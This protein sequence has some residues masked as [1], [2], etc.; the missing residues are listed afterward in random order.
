MP[1]KKKKIVKMEDIIPIT[2]TL[3]EER[4]V[5]LP[6]EGRKDFNENLDNI[7]I[8]LKESAEEEIPR[9]EEKSME[10]ELNIPEYYKAE[11]TTGPQDLFEEQEEIKMPSRKKFNFKPWRK[12]R[13]ILIFA[14]IIIVLLS[15]I[16][17]PGLSKT[18]VT[19]KPKAENAHFKTELT[20]DKGIA[21]IDMSNNKIPAQL[22]KVEKEEK[23]EFP[24]TAEKDLAERAKGKITV[25]NQYSSVQQILVKST[26]FLSKDN[27]MFRTTRTIIIPGA[28]VENG[29]II[30]SSVDV[31]VIAVEPG[32]SYNIG[33]SKFTIP[34]FKGT[35]KYAGFYGESK[36][37]M[38]GG[39][40]GKVRVVSAEDIQGAKDVLLAE[41]K[42]QAEE[43]LKKQIPSNL[44][45]L[46]KSKTEEVVESSSNVKENQPAEK[47]TE[48]VK[49]AIKE[50]A[51]DKKNAI[52]LVNDN[53]RKKL[54]ESKI[55]IPNT[56]K[57]SYSI[58][59]INLE[60]GWAKLSVDAEETVAP[61][62]DTEKIKKDIAKKNEIEVRQYFAS[63]SDIE[64]VKISF[65][66]FWVK[67]VS[68]KKDKIKINVL[69]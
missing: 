59:D 55:I 25:Y 29:Q 46:E 1:D 62:I 52:S 22:F 53:F 61:K 37:P 7:K 33:P 10:S 28:K 45:I 50:L 63:F 2:R 51:F 39:I 11:R 66:P 4:E 8:N 47:F 15:L 20:I 3:E 24:A 41:L 68:S 48:H 54:S 14:G 43:N 26:R 19:I 64:N 42:N 13:K 57:I 67:K 16:L 60:K 38:S 35:A 69:Y 21:F 56:T 18:E 58:V 17:W 40:K 27:K 30:P 12:K 65:W 9:E 34:G 31:E 49:I 23:K 6:E 5:L 36:E 44:E 32:E